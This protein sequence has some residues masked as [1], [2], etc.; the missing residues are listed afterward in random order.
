MKG[1]LVDTHIAL[2]SVYDSKR[3]STRSVEVLSDPSTDKFLSH[4]S[5]WEV[6]IKHQAH[7]DKMEVSPAEFAETARKAGYS[8][9][10]APLEAILRTESL[11]YASELTAGHKDPFDRLLLCH[12]QAE[13][14]SF[15]THDESL[16]GY[17]LPFLIVA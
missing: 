1:I 11:P 13:G 12:A 4:I 2:W 17:K 15:L 3:L 10:P 6:A 8:L 16:A 7:P 5:V 9:T 14:L